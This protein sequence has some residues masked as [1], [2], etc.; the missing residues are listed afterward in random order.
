MLTRA[1]EYGNSRIV[2]GVHYPL[3][4]IA[5]RVLG[6]Y[7]VAQMLNNNPQY[8]NAT[9]NGVFGIGDVTTTSNFQTA[10]HG[11]A[12]RRA[13]SAADRLRH[14]HRDLFGDRRAGPFQQSAA[15]NRADYTARLT[16]GLPTLSFAQAPR[17]AAP[18]GGPD[19]SILL[20]TA[21]RRQFHRGEDYRADRR[22]ATAA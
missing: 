22:P 17:E 11:G 10:V 12:D 14:R 3:D 13:Q 20:A 2:L 15:Q 9:V 6:T 21:L 1:S 16:Y 8:T 4:I 7:D 19:A 5:G 18:A